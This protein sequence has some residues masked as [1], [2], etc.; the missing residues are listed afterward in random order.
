MTEVGQIL[1]GQ[2]HD[3]ST[4]SP[5]YHC[6]APIADVLSCQGLHLLAEGYQL[7]NLFNDINKKFQ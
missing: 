2:L 7:I 6:A 3:T 5:S 1:I 4:S